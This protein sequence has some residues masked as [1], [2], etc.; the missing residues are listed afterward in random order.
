MGL[1]FWK[2]YKNMIWGPATQQAVSACPSN[3]MSGHE[4][5]ALEG[6]LFYNR[7]MVIRAQVL[8]IRCRQTIESSFAEMRAHLYVRKLEGGGARP[9]GCRWEGH[10]RRV[11]KSV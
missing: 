5:N 7:K 6:S 8:S 1:A 9:L 3:V 10:D 11:A 2:C 4:R